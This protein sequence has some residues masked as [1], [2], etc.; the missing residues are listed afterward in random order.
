M[1]LY[2]PTPQVE[3]APSP[4]FTIADV[5]AW[6]RTKPVG[7]EYDFCDAGYCAVAQFGRATGRRHLIDLDSA[8]LKAYNPDVANA[9]AEFPWTFGALVGRLERLSA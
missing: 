2:D 8:D 4:D 5:L 1:A 7:G 3:V 9:A 6:A